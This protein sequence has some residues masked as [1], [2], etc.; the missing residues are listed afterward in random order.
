VFFSFFTFIGIIV[1]DKH[2]EGGGWQ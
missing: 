2:I 1:Y